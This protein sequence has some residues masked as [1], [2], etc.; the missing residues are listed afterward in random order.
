MFFKMPVLVYEELNCIDNHKNELAQIGI[1]ALIITGKSSSKRNGSLND[2]TVAL[3]TVNVNY[4]IFDEVEENPSV[5]TVMKARDFGLSENVDFIIGLGGGSPLDAAKAVAIMISNK[6]ESSDFLYKTGIVC[7][8]LPVVAIPTTCGTGSEVTAISVLTVHS[9]KTKEAIPHKVFPVL[10]LV[11]AK[12]L[13]SAPKSLL[14]ATALDA[15][16]HFIESYINTSTTDFS[17][18]FVNEGLKIWS[19]TKDI[20]LGIKSPDY[21]DYRNLINASTLAGMAISHTGTSLPHGLS[22]AL[23]YELGM[24]HGIAVSYFLNGFINE[25]SKYDRKHLL[26]ISGFETLDDFQLFFEHTCGKITV[27][28]SV[29]SRTINDLSV[30]DIKIKSC[31]YPV[32]I[33]TIKKIAKYSKAQL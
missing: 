15:F 25:A 20:L 2:L 1:K 23:T 31:P 13:A 3:E 29:L 16:G 28:N 17:R 10:A 7:H 33:Q 21:E 4:T 19:K 11:D 5:E 30:N 9:K 12:Y 26:K 27:P 18:M 24:P 22:Y 32:D 8:A 14:C 6:D